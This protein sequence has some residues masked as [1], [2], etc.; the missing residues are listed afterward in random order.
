MGRRRVIIT[1]HGRA[2]A[3]PAEAVE[4]SGAAGHIAT[5]PELE[6]LEQE[7]ANEELYGG[8]AGAIAAAGLGAASAATFSA[9][10]WL[11]RQGG[12]GDTLRQL[13]DRHKVATF[14]GQLVGGVGA[15]GAVSRA[16]GK[17]A[18]GAVGKLTAEG[19][20]YGL[21]QGGHELA[22][23]EEPLTAE[24]VVGVLGS[25]ALGGA[26]FGGVL[27]GATKAARAGL[28]R[29]NRFIS[30]TRAKAEQGT[31]ASGVV[32][33]IAGHHQAVD[34][35]GIWL[36]VENQG[37]RKVL[38]D[39]AR[40]VR[41]ELDDPV[42]LAEAPHRVIKPLRREVEV[43]KKALKDAPALEAKIVAEEAGIAKKIRQQLVKADEKTQVQ[44][45]PGATIEMEPVKITG[46]GAQRF[47][48]WSGSKVSAAAARRG[49]SVTPDEA[50]AF[51]GALEAGEVAGMRAKGIANLPGRIERAQA[52]VDRIEVEREALK[53]A[54]KAPYADVMGRRIA[55]AG[56][57]GLIGSVA[58]GMFGMPG[59]GAIGS[60][61]ASELV[62]KGVS[63]VG[64]KLGRGVAAST[65]ATGKAAAAIAG[66]APA[67]KALTPDIRAFLSGST[68]SAAAASLKAA[69]RKRSSE[70]LAQTTMG[71]DGEPT[72]RMEAR[73][74]LGRQLAPVASISPKLADR[75]ET[76]AARRAAFL[77]KK[78]PR[79]PDIYGPNDPWEPGDSEMRS[80]GRLAWA[81]E[82]PDEVEA[83]LAHGSIT[84][85]DAEAFQ[86]VYP[87][88]F[89]ELAMAIAA[90]IPEIR[91]KMPYQ[92]R[93]ALSI[94]TGQAVDP[95]LDP[96]V[97]NVLQSNFV[98]EE[99]TAGGTQA[100][101]ADP[102]FAS[103]EMPEPTPAQERAG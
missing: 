14:A 75:V 24:R 2:V 43:L 5:E 31:L 40:A 49:V 37:D 34:A 80:W 64:R 88:R 103:M 55:H 7:R 81:A 82:H 93:L 47:G 51:A 102:R 67:K 61:L 92:R 72:M 99:G 9:S 50:A 32:D 17:V 62:H 69:Y 48:Q 89:R 76:V 22:L 71:P 59:A 42:G 73:M 60:V 4:E 15:A 33:E 56:A 10:D 90:R 68:K 58:G 45:A 1:P 78:L 98:L 65:K 21:G 18:S 97:L 87:E 83:R 16:A 52:L 54:A 100:P 84:P 41:G 28:K 79:R 23:D 44:A 74:A 66:A 57:M 39:A 86:E 70:V 95:S 101:H 20:L 77:A 19:A 91:A 36:A 46:K 38:N 85:E 27:G 94:F 11:L 13:A 12:G 96:R 63:F 53:Q 30:A 29:G 35:E 3:A 8:P 6:A 26:A 25:R